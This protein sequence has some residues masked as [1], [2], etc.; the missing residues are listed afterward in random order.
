M[1]GVPHENP[2]PNTVCLA[3][4]C[5]GGMDYTALVKRTNKYQEKKKSSMPL[6]SLS[7]IVL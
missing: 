1:G 7:C 5:G 2:W 6:G 4:S 3:L